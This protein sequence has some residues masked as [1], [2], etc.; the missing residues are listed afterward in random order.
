LNLPVCFV[1][2]ELRMMKASFQKQLREVEDKREQLIV[3][4]MRE[5]NEWGRQKKELKGVEKGL[6]M[7]LERL[8]QKYDACLDAGSSR[9]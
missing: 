7:Q 6:L 5:Q 3:E 1:K 2:E 8:Q 4:H 9:R